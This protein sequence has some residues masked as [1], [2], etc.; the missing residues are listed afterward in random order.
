MKTRSG[1]V[2]ISAVYASFS[3]IHNG[4]NEFST[5]DFYPVKIIIYL[6]TFDQ[7]NFEYGLRIVRIQFPY[8]V[9]GYVQ[10]TFYRSSVV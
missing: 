6:Q 7:N 2:L 5:R 9:Y 4:R 1:L 3:A 10:H 8:I